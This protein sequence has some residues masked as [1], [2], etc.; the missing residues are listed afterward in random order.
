MYWQNCEGEDLRL[1]IVDLHVSVAVTRKNKDNRDEQG[2][3]V[4]CTM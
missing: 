1:A 3:S 4:D 2:Y